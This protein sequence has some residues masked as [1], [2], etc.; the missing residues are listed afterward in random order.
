MKILGQ[1]PPKLNELSTGKTLEKSSRS[2]VEK[3]AGQNTK[4]SRLVTNDAAQTAHRI[5]ETLR[6][7]PD[8]RPDRVEEVKEKIRT[9][10][11]QVEP[12]R[13]AENMLAASLKEDLEKP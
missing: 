1:Q 2:D 12:E 6:A 5:K 13:L 4:E 7:E 10:K 8:I 11:Y 3:A 9:G